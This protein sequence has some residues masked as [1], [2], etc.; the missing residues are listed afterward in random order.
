MLTQASSYSLK[1]FSPDYK[2]IRRTF[3]GGAILAIG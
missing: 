1:S 3:P 2:Y